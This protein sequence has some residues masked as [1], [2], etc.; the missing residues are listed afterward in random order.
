MRLPL[1]TGER[2]PGFWRDG[3]WV[4]VL[5]AAGVLLPGVWWAQ[6]IRHSGPPRLGD[7]KSPATYGFPLEN[8]SVDLTT[9]VGS[10]FPRSSIPALNQ[11]GSV[12]LAEVTSLGRR[13]LLPGDPV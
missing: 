1:G 8:A 7:G 4:L 9:L 3:R 6:R 2:Q 10:V 13:F 12:S 5:I 11:P